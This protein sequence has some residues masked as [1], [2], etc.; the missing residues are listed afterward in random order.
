[1]PQAAASKRE[2]IPRK[3]TLAARRA[4]REG[5]SLR[6]V[7]ISEKTETRYRAGVTLL[8]PFLEQAESLEELDP[9]CED[10][11]EQN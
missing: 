10:W 6:A 2:R 8:L 11:V 3:G 9:I 1:M 4:A 5:V 7:G